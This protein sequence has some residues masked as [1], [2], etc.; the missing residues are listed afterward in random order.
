VDLI[1]PTLSVIETPFGIKLSVLPSDETL[2]KVI[3]SKF[4]SPSSNAGSHAHGI[5]LE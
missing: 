4:Y 2:S 3:K 1:I 5:S